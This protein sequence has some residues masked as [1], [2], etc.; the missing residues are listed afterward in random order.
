MNNNIFN[1]KKFLLYESDKNSEQIQKTS[2]SIDK[3][4]LLNDIDNN[5]KSYDFNNPKMIIYRGINSSEP[6][7]MISPSKSE[8]RSSGA[9]VKNYYTFILDNSKAWS[10][11]PKRSRSVIG[12]Q[13]EKYASMYGNIYVMLPFDNANFGSCPKEDLVFSFRYL[14]ERKFDAIDFNDLLGNFYESIYKKSLDN[15]SW[16]GLKND[17]QKFDDKSEQDMIKK[18]LDKIKVFFMKELW[19]NFIY[20]N[21]QNLS[22]IDYIGNIIFNPIQNGFKNFIWDKNTKI[23]PNKEV[24]TDSNVF[25]IKEDFFKDIKNNFI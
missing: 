1:Y 19:N 5:C 23:I 10:L 3:Q 7:L 16:Q 11:Y 20:Q 8:R 2:I 6:Y 17:L 24:W 22:F 13:S 12:I 9:G 18:K 25:L 14:K 21:K 15:T 4:S